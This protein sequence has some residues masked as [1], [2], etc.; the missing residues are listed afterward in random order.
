MR[1]A[2]AFGRIAGSLGRRLVRVT[3]PVAQPTSTRPAIKTTIR[4]TISGTRLDARPRAEL[5][6]NH[7]LLHKLDF[8]RHATLPVYLPGP[9]LP[10]LCKV[11]TSQID[12]AAY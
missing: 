10:Q 12:Q 8:R 9:L 2:A 6:I 7:P 4:L 3:L 1:P 11:W 5:L